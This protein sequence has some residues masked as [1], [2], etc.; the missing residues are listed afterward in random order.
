MDS[1]LDASQVVARH[2][3][4]P[5]E[6]LDQLGQAAVYSVADRASALAAEGDIGA[7]QRVL[8]NLTHSSESFGWEEKRVGDVVAVMKE[9]H[10]LGPDASMSAAAAYGD[11]LQRAVGAAFDPST[12]AGKAFTGLG[13]GL[14]SLSV[15]GRVS[16]GVTNPV[17]AVAFG[18]T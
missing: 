17:A 12:R 6:F 13:L 18:A 9:A 11:R 10:A 7:T 5:D 8:D 16:N 1:F 4:K 3:G 2:T 15:I 14:G